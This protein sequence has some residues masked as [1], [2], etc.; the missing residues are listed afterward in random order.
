MP[1][2]KCPKCGVGR[3]ELKKA[4]PELARTLA[5]LIE[6]G[7]G[8]SAPEMLDWFPGITTTAINNRLEELRKDGL[9]RRKRDGRCW[10]YWPV[11]GGM[12]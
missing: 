6:C 11:D 8:Y 9:V 4:F 1:K 12:K 7:G 2:I 3:I 5:Y 10:R